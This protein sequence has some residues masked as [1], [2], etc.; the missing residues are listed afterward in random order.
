MILGAL[1]ALGGQRWLEEQAGKNPVAFM[2]LLG[3]VLPTFRARMEE[4]SSSRL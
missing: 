2:T 4:Q 3:K 1:S